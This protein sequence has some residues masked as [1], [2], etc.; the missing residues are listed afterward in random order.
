MRGAL[1]LAGHRQGRTIQRLADYVDESSHLGAAV[2]VGSFAKGTADDL[3]DVDLFLIATVGN[4]Q[5]AWE[6]RR[7]LHVTGSV[8]RGTRAEGSSS[9]DTGGSHRI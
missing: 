9:A 6:A 4:F 8:P 2:L 1:G 5:Q 3:S 7:Y